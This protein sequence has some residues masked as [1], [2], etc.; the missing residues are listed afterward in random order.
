ME[1]EDP[2]APA[3][4]RGDSYPDRVETGNR[5][6]TRAVLRLATVLKKRAMDEWER[7]ELKRPYDENN[8]TG[9]DVM[10]GDAT[11]RNDPTVNGDA[12]NE[13]GDA[14]NENS[15]AARQ[16]PGGGGGPPTNPAPQAQHHGPVQMIVAAAEGAHAAVGAA[17]DA[18][19]AI[20][21]AAVDRPVAVGS[22]LA[23]SGDRFVAAVGAELA[24]AGDAA[25]AAA[26]HMIVS[27]AQHPSSGASPQKGETGT[28]CRLNKIGQGWLHTCADESKAEGRIRQST[29][30]GKHR[31]NIS[32]S[33]S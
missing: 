18:T 25:D 19:G 9:T 16:E 23:A 30:T 3:G 24:A 1:K 5:S 8:S 11:M 4:S 13:N 33:C 21:G 29:E 27:A 28:G 12:T 7:G 22:E 31:H 26:T 32:I 14:T 20:L 6:F 17:V 15:I 2:N 10:N